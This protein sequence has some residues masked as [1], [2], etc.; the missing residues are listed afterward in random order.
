MPRKF[1]DVEKGLLNK[2]FQKSNSHHVFYIYH[3]MSGLKTPIKTKA[4]HGEREISDNLLA[5]MAKQVKLKKS[6]FL[7]LVDCPL[8]REEYESI[9][10]SENEIE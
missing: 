9:L 2:G 6:D 5:L 4:S 10:R 7:N 8:K 1:N 3:D